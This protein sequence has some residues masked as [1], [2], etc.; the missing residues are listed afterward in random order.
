MLPIIYFGVYHLRYNLLVLMLFTLGPSA[1]I[2][3]M[4]P[5]CLLEFVGVLDPIYDLYAPI[6]VQNWR[7]QW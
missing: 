1:M 2:S 4:N 5:L 6:I 3:D 7:S